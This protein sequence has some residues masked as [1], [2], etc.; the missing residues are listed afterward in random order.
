M[1]KA[2]LSVLSHSR[3]SESAFADALQVARDEMNQWTTAQIFLEETFSQRTCTDTKFANALQEI[4]L[5]KQK[6]I[7]YIQGQLMVALKKEG[8]PAMG[9]LLTPWLT[10]RIERAKSTK[11]ST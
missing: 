2:A 5:G 8:L 9:E 10:Q 6:A 7:G 4:H 11:E 1:L 3:W